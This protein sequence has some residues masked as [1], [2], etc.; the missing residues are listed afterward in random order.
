MQP[1]WTE[2]SAEII[3][4]GIPVLASQRVAKHPLLWTCIS[5]NLA[6]NLYHSPCIIELLRADFV[7][8]VSSQSWIAMHWTDMA[9]RAWI[10]IYCFGDN[11][12]YVYVRPVLRCCQLVDPMLGV[13][14]LEMWNIFLANFQHTYRQKKTSLDLL[15]L[16]SFQKEFLFSYILAMCCNMVLASS[17]DDSVKS[18]LARG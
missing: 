17:R 12:R 9:T 8:Q 15:T 18:S 7:R 5:D 4:M 11:R 1:P 16:C 2:F 10:P 6:T 14:D 3:Q 13:R